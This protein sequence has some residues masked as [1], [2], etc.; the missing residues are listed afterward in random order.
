MKSFEEFIEKGIVKIRSPN[1]SLAKDLIEESARKYNS[2]K[3]IIEKLGINQNNANDIIEYCY[4]ILIGL[5][6]ARIYLEGF[7][8]SGEGAHEAE[9]SYLF[10]IGFSNKKVRFMDELRFFRNRI[11]YYGK[12]FDENY[13]KIVIEFLEENYLKIRN[14]ISL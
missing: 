6:R 13:A 11:K 7:K 14:L 1:K 5:I 2:L 9:I 8:C 3:E 12:R 4:D 10:K